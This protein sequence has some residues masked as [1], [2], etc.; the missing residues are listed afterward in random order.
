M[1]F[2]QCFKINKLMQ[3]FN[4]GW[5]IAGGWAI[6]LFLEKKTRN[7][8]D[9]EIVIARNDQLCLKEYLHNWTFNKVFR[10]KL[11]T[12]ENEYLELPI[13]E[14][15]GENDKTKD[16]LEVLLN[17]IELNEWKFR[18]DKSITCKLDSLYSVS[19]EGIPYLNPEIVLLYKV[20]NTREKDHQ[21]FKNVKDY[22]DSSQKT[23]LREA[24]LIHHPNHEWL[25]DLK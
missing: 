7:H 18:R 10:G 23:W 12:W 5:Y 13:H 3:D 15:H 9:L 22:L 14:I 25:E 6:D 8:H 4:K 17:E 20:R 19:N 1:S 24:I 2:E 11:S 21:D 16:E